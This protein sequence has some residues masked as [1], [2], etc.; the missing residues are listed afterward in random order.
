MPVDAAWCA[1]VSDVPACR[2]D[3]SS[4]IAVSLPLAL[5]IGRSIRFADEARLAQASP[6]VPD[7][8]PAAWLTPAE[9]C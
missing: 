3:A 1:P 4:R 8:V 7:F 6:A 5:L 9:S 2:A